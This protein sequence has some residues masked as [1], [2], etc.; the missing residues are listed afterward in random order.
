MFFAN[1]NSEPDPAASRSQSASPR[2][3]ESGRRKKA[4]RACSKAEGY[5]PVRAFATPDVHT[6]TG[7][8]VSWYLVA[9]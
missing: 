9:R 3:L 8:P 5:F 6:C 7:L 1:G 2:L 4:R